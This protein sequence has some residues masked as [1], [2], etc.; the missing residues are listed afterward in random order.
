MKLRSVFIFIV[1]GI[2]FLTAC[3]G[4]SPTPNASLNT[5]TPDPTV[6]E[7]TSTLSPAFTLTATQTPASV[8]VTIKPDEAEVTVRSGPG[9]TYAIVGKL[10][11]G[12]KIAALG[13]SK[14]SGWFQIEFP[15]SPDGKAW[16]FASLVD[17]T[18]GNLPAV[19]PGNGGA[20]APDSSPTAQMAARPEAIAAIQR[21]LKKDNVS[22]VYLGPDTNLNSPSLRKVDRY[23][24][25][26]VTYSIDWETNWIVQIDASRSAIPSGT[27]FTTAELAQKAFMVVAELAPG[28]DLNALSPQQGSKG[29]NYFFRWDG[30]AAVGFIQVGLTKTGA[31]LT[32]LNALSNANS[33]QAIQ[34]LSQGANPGSEQVKTANRIEI[35]LKNVRRANGKLEADLCFSMPDNEDWMLRKL[36]LR[37]AG[38][39]QIGDWGSLIIPPIVPAAN[40]QPGRRCDSIYFYVPDSADLSEFTITVYSIDAYPREGMM[41][42]R[43]ESVQQKLDA[44]KIKMVCTS[45]D[46]S[47]SYQIVEKPASMSE[48][49]AQTLAMEIIDRTIKGPWEFTIHD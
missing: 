6:V 10:Q 18:P 19:D 32:Y 48:T 47:D 9:T 43:I 29:E 30:G 35:H 22:F 24:V 46:H 27:A 26:D 14:G 25:D 42:T 15:Q 20:T 33:V 5:A 23:T 39:E 4:T 2:F 34:S 8:F 28:I 7:P 16:V 38:S 31:L 36:S 12:Q 37:Y 13:I 3:A 1:G 40:G 44:L 11:P 45:G 49:E 21:Y 17:R 41:C